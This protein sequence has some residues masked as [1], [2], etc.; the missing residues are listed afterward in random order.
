MPSTPWD[1]SAA[2]QLPQPYPSSPTKLPPLHGKKAQDH[3]DQPAMQQKK[4]L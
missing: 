1:L 3:S 2:T 4:T